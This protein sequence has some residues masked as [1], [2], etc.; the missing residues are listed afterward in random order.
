[1]NS[2][3]KWLVLW[4]IQL[5]E[6]AS[7]YPLI[8]ITSKTG[9]YLA[10][11]NYKPN[12]WIELPSRRDAIMPVLPL[13]DFLNFETTEACRRRHIRY[14]SD[15][16]AEAC[17]MGL[18]E[19]F[20]NPLIH[21]VSWYSVTAQIEFQ[22]RALSSLNKMMQLSLSPSAVQLQLDPTLPFLERNPAPLFEH[23]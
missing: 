21:L 18:Q 4:A 11:P 1:M 12:P 22:I 7:Q 23:Q 13:L 6:T 19:N 5:G 16:G 14:D 2:R 17:A 8:P 9:P 20:I 15:G 10:Y 3:S